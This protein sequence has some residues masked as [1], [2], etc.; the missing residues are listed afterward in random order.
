[1]NETRL[2]DEPR[3]IYGVFIHDLCCPEKGLALPKCTFYGYPD[4]IVTEFIIYTIFI[5]EAP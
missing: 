4:G 1:M 3:V 2:A 5:L